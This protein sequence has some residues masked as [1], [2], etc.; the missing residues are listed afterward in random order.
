MDSQS[1][2]RIADNANCRGFDRISVGLLKQTAVISEVAASR[3]PGS[4]RAR[5]HSAMQHPAITMQ[6][7]RRQTR[8]PKS[9]PWLIGW[10]QLLSH[11]TLIVLP[12]FS[13]QASSLV[14]CTLPLPVPDAR[15]PVGGNTSGLR[16]VSPSIP[17]QQPRSVVA[18]RRKLGALV[19]PVLLSPPDPGS[20]SHRCRTGSRP[21][22][23]PLHQA[24]PGREL[25]PGI[26]HGAQ[27]EATS[28]RFRG[29][30]RALGGP[31]RRTPGPSDCKMGN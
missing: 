5:G 4:R 7:G 13:G 20:R 1:A 8:R 17:W 26:R 12:R 15:I 16:P 18:E 14:I 22:L 30:N 11:F 28:R 10:W 21:S 29:E 27:A 19:S 25:G 9:G 3:Q 23:R 24:R 31:L 6:T 2:F